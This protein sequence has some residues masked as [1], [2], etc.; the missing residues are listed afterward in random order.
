MLLSCIQL[1]RAFTTKLRDDSISAFACQAAFFIILSIFP[2]LMFLLTLINYLPFSVD[3]LGLL[4]NDIIP[5]SIVTL[6]QTILNELIQKSSGTLLSV[7]VIAALWSASSGTVALLK[8]LNAVYRHKETRNYFLLRGISAFYT[9]VFAILLILMLVLL[10]FGNQLYNFIMIEL[11]IFR[12]LAMMVLNLRSLFTMAVLTLFFLMV[13]L[14]L[15]NRKS[16]IFRELPGAIISAG[17]WLLFSYLFSYYIDNMGN[18]SYTYGSLA[19]IAISM[20][21][22]YFCMFILFIGAEI[23]MILSHP[24]V[25]QATHSLFSHKK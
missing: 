25:I 2:F 21:W 4:T 20:L 1:V 6:L 8:G 11:P 18:Y 13:Y 19:A 7:S 5:E 10:V 23:N 14:I 24:E 17:G 9:L 3:E 12:N 16:N 22:L 15:P